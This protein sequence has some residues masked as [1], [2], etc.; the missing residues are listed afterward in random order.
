MTDAGR[1]QAHSHDSE[2]KYYDPEQQTSPSNDK[3][4]RLPRQTATDGPCF[5]RFGMGKW[6]NPHRYL[7]TG[8]IPQ[9]M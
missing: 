1:N 8:E 3:T 4:R 9:V 5:H 2:P 7:L 6:P